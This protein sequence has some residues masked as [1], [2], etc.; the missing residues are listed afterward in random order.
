ML[1]PSGLPAHLLKSAFMFWVTRLTSI[2]PPSRGVWRGSLP[3]SV[4]NCGLR[5]K[6]LGW[7]SS[8][9]YTEDRSARMPGWSTSN[10]ESELQRAPHFFHGNWATNP[11]GQINHGNSPE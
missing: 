11:R 10:A 1:A 7:S 4:L 2:A 9:E 8:G 3:Q 6:R 5:A